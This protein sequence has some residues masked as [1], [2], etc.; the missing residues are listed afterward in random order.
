MSLFKT[1]SEEL[2]G[3]VTKEKFKKEIFEIRNKRAMF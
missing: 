1:R 2:R 3:G